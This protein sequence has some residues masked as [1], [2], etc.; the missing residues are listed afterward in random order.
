[1]RIQQSSRWN[2]H[3]TLL[4]DTAGDDKKDAVALA[5][6]VQAVLA[7]AAGN[8]L[9]SVAIP[10]IGNGNAGWPTALAAKAHIE[11]L[12]QFVAAIKTPSGLKVSMT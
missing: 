11:A 6:T 9:Q 8:G 10:L 2:A 12:M 7:E 5:S 3:S 4:C 1:M